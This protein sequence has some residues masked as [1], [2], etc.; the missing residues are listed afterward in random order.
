MRVTLFSWKSDE[1][2]RNLF[3]EIAF[4]PIPRGCHQFIVH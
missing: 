1:S 3:V 4:I 2:V